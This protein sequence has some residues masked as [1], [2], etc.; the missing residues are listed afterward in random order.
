MTYGKFIFIV[1]VHDTFGE[2]GKG[3]VAVIIIVIVA[4]VVIVVIIMDIGVVAHGVSGCRVSG[5]ARLC[6]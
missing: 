4:I 1:L 6:Q 3:S 2:W 5:D